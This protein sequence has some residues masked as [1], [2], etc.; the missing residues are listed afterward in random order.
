[1][2]RIDVRRSTAGIRCP[3]QRDDPTPARRRVILMGDL[4]GKF[5]SQAL[6]ASL[7]GTAAVR[8]YD[9]IGAFQCTIGWI[10]LGYRQA[11]LYNNDLR[12]YC[13]R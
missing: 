7:G 2:N 12:L 8:I 10:G 11:Y 4:S 6:L 5:S 9:S 13:A 3:F 1:V